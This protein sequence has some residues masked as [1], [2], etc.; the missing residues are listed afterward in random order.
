MSLFKLKQLCCQGIGVKKLEQVQTDL[1]EASKGYVEAVIKNKLSDTLLNDQKIPAEY[2]K[3]YEKYLEY[4][5]ATLKQLNKKQKTRARINVGNRI[6]NPQ[7]KTLVPAY[8]Q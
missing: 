7:V 5:E 1:E 4:L 8:A 2:K 3:I 6:S